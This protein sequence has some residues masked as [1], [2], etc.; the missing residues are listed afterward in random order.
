MRTVSISEDSK[1]KGADT[2]TTWRGKI[3]KWKSLF[4]VWEKFDYVYKLKSK[5]PN[6]WEKLKIH[7]RMKIIYVEDS[8]V[9]CGVLWAEIFVVGRRK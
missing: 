1:K 4:G 5:E 2:A 6:S 7:G 9:M 8:R 3:T